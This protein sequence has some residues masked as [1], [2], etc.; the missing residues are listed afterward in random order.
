MKIAG[1]FCGSTYFI[2]IIA[3]WSPMVEMGDTGNI[4]DGFVFADMD[5]ETTAKQKSPK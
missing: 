4:R 2:N 5:D 3:F 1:V